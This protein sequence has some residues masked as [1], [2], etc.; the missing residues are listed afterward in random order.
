[1]KR[2]LVLIG[3]ELALPL[4]VVA[5]WWVWS[6]TAESFYFPPLPDILRT[7]ADA[8]IFKHVRSDV[9]PSL[10]RLGFGFAI[11]VVVGISLGLVLG[12]A[13]RARQTMAPVV[14]FLRA[15]PAPALI[16]V[17]IVLLGIGDAMRIA[18]IANVCTWPILLNAIDGVA[19]TDT[20]LVATAT[21][22]RLRRLDRIRFV[23]LPAALPQIFAGMRT[24]LSLGIIVMVISEM[25]ASSNGIGYFV[26]RSQRTF[27]IPAMWA[28]ILLLGVL[29][30]SLNHGFARIE[31]RVL[32]WHRGWRANALPRT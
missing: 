11:A 2:R 16:P 19:G 3:A 1:M 8:W 12:M 13:P 27:D 32:R 23:M 17:G 4:V 20:S 24:S 25:E 10:A 22:Y 6:T 14:E 21:S 31:S 26:L 18:I 9:L 28:G 15:I 29:G 30:Y 7:F 5:V